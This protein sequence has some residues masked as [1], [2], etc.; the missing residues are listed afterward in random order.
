MKIRKALGINAAS[1]LIIFVVNFTSIIVISRLLTPEEIGIFSV[2]VSILAFAHIFREFGVGQFLIQT[3]Q[4]TNERLRAA[5]TVTLS[6]SWLIAG[7]LVLASTPIAAFY[8]SEGI[9][10][11][12]RLIA[13]NFVILPFGAPLISLLRRDMAFDKIAIVNI[14]NAVVGTAATISAALL[15]ESYL[16][17][18]WGAV[19]GN[20][21]NVLLLNIMRPGQIFMLPS[22]RGVPEVLRFGS[23]TSASAIITELG[24]SAPDLILGRTLGFSA[25]AYYSRANGLRTMALGQIITLVR[26]VYLPSFA[27]DVR[28]G[29]DPA[30]LYC[31]AMNYMAAFSAPALAVLAVLAEPLILFLFGSQWVETAPLATL[32]CVFAI[33]TTPTS[34]ASTSLVASGNVGLLLRTQ[35][36]IQS[37]KALIL[38]SSIWLPLDEVVL[39]LG[40][41]YLIESFVLLR[42]LWTAFQLRTRTL[43]HSLRAAYTLVPLSIIGPIL[44]LFAQHL[45]AWSPQPL[46]TLA[47]SGLLALFGWLF[48]LLITEHPLKGEASALFQ[49]I[50]KDRI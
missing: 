16:S 29:R 26:G 21:S 28:E 22:L 18:A 3:N 42:S 49:K 5:F 11:V 41:A 25:V 39:A 47:L 10:D 31:R 45:L 44:V 36:V 30:K 50:T 15:G 43:L 40:L 17:M 7:A 6:I 27:R 8:G 46:V 48:G 20:V 19:A 24:N 13:I 14:S 37:S 4:V 9:T 38:L 33:L 35:I 12:L 1:Q 32:I 23:L 2:S 34:L